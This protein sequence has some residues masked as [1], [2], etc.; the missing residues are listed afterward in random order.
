MDVIITAEEGGTVWR[1]TDLLGRSMGSITKSASH[2]F[3]IC[4][5]GHASETMAGIQQGAYASLDA[6][7]AEIEKHTRGACRRT[8]EAGADFR[9]PEFCVSACSGA[10]IHL[11]VYPPH[12]HP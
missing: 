5:A 10:N 11:S 6:A 7:L 9:R 3:A 2:H 8:P 1:L 4:P 12:L